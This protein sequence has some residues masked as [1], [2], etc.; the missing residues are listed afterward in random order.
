MDVD[1]ITGVLGRIKDIYIV[2]TVF[3]G[4]TPESYLLF[5]VPCPTEQ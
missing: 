2:L 5:P 1:K 4:I 3:N